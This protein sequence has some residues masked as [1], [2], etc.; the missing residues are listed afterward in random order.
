MNVRDRLTRAV[1][2]LPRVD[3]TEPESNT[4]FGVITRNVGVVSETFI[5]RHMT[6]LLP[7]ET[8]V[9]GRHPA[10]PGVPPPDAPTLILDHRARTRRR[11][12]LRKA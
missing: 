5:R 7:G 1:L 11:R 12:T 4:P 2:S 9:V 10:E 3:S 6:D 8:V